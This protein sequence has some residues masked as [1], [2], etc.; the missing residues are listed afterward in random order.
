MNWKNIS[1][2]YLKELK[3]SLRD[4][5]T[6]MSMIIIPTLVM[7]LMFF[8]VGYVMKVVIAKAQED[9]SPVMIVGGADSPG[10]VQIYGDYSPSGTFC[11]VS[12][13]PSRA[14]KSQAA[15]S[16]SVFDFIR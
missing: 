7:P 14:M 16:A 11:S 10:I 9:A 1:T 6:L 15:R 4:R 3:D 2:I 12:S 8:G 13:P 5:R